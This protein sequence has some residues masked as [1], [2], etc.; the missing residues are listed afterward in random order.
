MPKVVLFDLDGTLL[1]SAPD[2]LHCAEQAAKAHGFVPCDFASAH[3]AISQG[4][5]G[6]LTHIVPKT[7]DVLFE[8]ML[9]TMLALYETNCYTRSSLYEGV[10]DLLTHLEIQAISWGIVTNKSRRF[11]NLIVQAEPAL[12]SA[13]VCICPE[14][15]HKPKPNP[16]G[17]ES[18]CRILGVSSSDCWYIGD[19]TKDMQ[20]SQAAACRFAF[21]AYGYAEHPL[22]NVPILKQPLDFL[23]FL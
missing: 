15:I 7:T 16:A 20:A 3:H 22:L 13:Q 6:I 9:T 17:I 18:A 2:L 8:Q 19:H 1:D 12:Q 14:D 23:N 4:A 10:M 11:T 21:A 5:R